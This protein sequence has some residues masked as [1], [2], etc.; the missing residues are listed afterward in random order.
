MT[1]NSETAVMTFKLRNPGFFKDLN[2]LMSTDRLNDALIFHPDNAAGQSLTV[3]FRGHT[4][5]VQKQEYEVL[6]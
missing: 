2:L 5:K 1:L 4:V 3:L 6:I